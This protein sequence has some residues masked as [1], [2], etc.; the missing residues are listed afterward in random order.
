MSITF[1]GHACFKIVSP[2]GTN[3]VIDPW[4]KNNPQAVD[5]FENVGKTDYILVSHG[6]G[7]HFGDTLELAEQ[8]GA[9]V[10]SIH[11]IS[12]YLLLKG[13][14]EERNIGMNKGGT[15]VLGDT[16]VTMVH[17]LHSSS[18]TEDDH[19]I[20]AGD[21]AGFVM[22][23]NNGFS[24]YYA[25]DTSVFGDMKL[26]ADMYKPELAILPI[27]DHYV[28][29]PEEGRWACQLINP[30]YVIPMHFG[31]FPV[32]T[33]TPDTFQKLMVKMPRVTIVVMKPGETIQ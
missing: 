21:A 15:V 28:M 19:I 13:I 6:H 3:I 4:L 25:G 16:R 1:F 9:T 33:G 2:D 17:A 8:S 24:L 32:L 27:G 30:H 20:Y 5:A 7:D 23:F 22:R 29:G 14:P 26:I 11:E 10:I 18:I 31:T 12:Q